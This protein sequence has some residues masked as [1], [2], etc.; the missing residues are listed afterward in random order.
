M[1]HGQLDTVNLVSQWPSVGTPVTFCAPSMCFIEVPCFDQELWAKLLL[2]LWTGLSNIFAWLKSTLQTAE[3]I[4]VC[5]HQIWRG[6]AHSNQ[7]LSSSQ[8]NNIFQHAGSRWLTLSSSSTLRPASST[9][10]P[11]S[12]S[13]GRC[14]PSLY[15]L[16][17]PWVSM[18]GLP[19][20]GCLQGEDQKA[21]GTVSSLGPATRWTL[22]WGWT[23]LF[24][25]W[26]R[27]STDSQ[28]RIE[29]TNISRERSS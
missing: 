4:C 21:W 12:F 1:P 6:L 8:A 20:V 9:S 5:C 29:P 18:R 19:T 13:G 2:P 15:H 17:P 25:G 26:T 23:R 7:C 14:L 24:Y 22:R 11:S 27:L 28:R 10:S 3:L 16:C